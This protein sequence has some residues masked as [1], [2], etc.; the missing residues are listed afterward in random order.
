MGI[1]SS[2][3]GDIGIV[4]LNKL[5][6]G[7]QYNSETSLLQIGDEFDFRDIRYQITDIDLAMLEDDE[8]TGIIAVHAQK[9]A[10]GDK[11]TP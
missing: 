3:A 2:S 5:L 4:P 10:S 6:I 11:V 8:T 7:M 1:F 9:R